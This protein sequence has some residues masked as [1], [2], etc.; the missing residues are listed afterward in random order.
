[1]FDDVPA[2]ALSQHRAEIAADA[3]ATARTIAA[4]YLSRGP[5]DGIDPV[6][7]AETLIRRDASD[8]F[9]ERLAPFEKRWALLVIR[10]LHPVADPSDAVKDAVDRGATWAEIGDALGIARQTAHK[11]FSGGSSRRRQNRP[12]QST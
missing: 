1:M 2:E 4:G 9:Y 11:H 6:L 8:S 5:G 12:I 10:L 3:L 7:V